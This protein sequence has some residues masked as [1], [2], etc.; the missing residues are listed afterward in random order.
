MGTV[1]CGRWGYTKQKYNNT[2]GGG[3][4]S[5]DVDFLDG[6]DGICFAFLNY[7]PISLGLEASGGG[8]GGDTGGDGGGD[9]DDV[10]PEQMVILLMVIRLTIHCRLQVLIKKHYE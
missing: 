3:D 5:V 8:G 7:E 4:D 6:I 1:E 9:D 10:D 2:K